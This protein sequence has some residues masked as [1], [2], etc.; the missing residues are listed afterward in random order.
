LPYYPYKVWGVKALVAA[1]KREIRKKSRWIEKNIKFLFVVP[2]IIYLLALLLFPAIFNLYASLHDWWIGRS[3]K[4]IGTENFTELIQDNR[5]IND[6]IVTFKFVI[7]AVTLEVGLGFLLALAAT[8]I[9]KGVQI[10]RVLFI[11]PIMVAPI[12]AGY[13]WRMLLH[14]DYGVIPNLLARLGFSRLEV[15]SNPKLA[16]WGIILIDVWQ[17]MP[18]VFLVTYA[19]L[20]ALPR[21]PYEA[22]LVDGAS[23]WQ[24]FRHITLPLISPI[25]LT[26]TLLR[27]V[28]AFK[29]FDIIYITTGGGPGIMTESL[30]LYVY[31]QGL[32]FFNLGYAGCIAWVFFLI[33]MVI[34]TLYIMRLR[35]EMKL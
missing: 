27:F 26:V 3:P 10:Y 1:K 31:I 24:I 2:A 34:T 23:S 15:L 9:T 29:V 25:L 4:F 14:A 28:E 13:M 33:V 7:I 32:K 16:F 21:E 22:A 19:G 18:F 5:F 17:W 11:F 6:V 30:S 20:T 35:K 8:K 12:A